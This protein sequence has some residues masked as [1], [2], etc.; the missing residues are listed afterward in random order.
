MAPGPLQRVLDPPGRVRVFRGWWI[1]FTGYLTQ[2]ASGGA[3]GW[4]F[5]VLILPMQDELGW[6]RSTIVGVLTLEKLVGGVYGV[7][8]GPRLDKY[9]NS[10][11]GI[12]ACTELASRLGLH[13]FDCLNIGSGFLETILSGLRHRPAAPLSLRTDAA[14]LDAHAA[15]RLHAHQHGRAG[16]ATGPLR[17]RG[18]R[19]DGGRLGP[20]AHVSDLR[21]DTL[22]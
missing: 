16:S 22:L 8:L 2:V 11:R 4:V 10:C 12:E 6:S 21:R 5:G 7:W 1:V 17:V 20:P 15:R 14:M 3:S 13:V 9:G 18:V 19:E